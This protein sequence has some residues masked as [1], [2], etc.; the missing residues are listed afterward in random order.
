MTEIQ[1]HQMKKKYAVWARY[2]GLAQEGRLHPQT[3]RLRI[4]QLADEMDDEFNTSQ[5]AGTRKR[6]Q[7]GKT[8]EPTPM[9]AS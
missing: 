8:S 6:V 7:D 1:P 9:E 4:K 3:D 2:Q 5:T